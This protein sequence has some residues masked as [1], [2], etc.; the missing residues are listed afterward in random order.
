[1]L[2]KKHVLIICSLFLFYACKEESKTTFSETSITTKTNKLVE[3][4]IPKVM[5][6]NAIS[7]SINSEIKNLVMRALQ[8]GE[9]TSTTSKSIEESIDAFNE[10]YNAFNKDFPDASMPW[11][12][13]I[14]GEMLFESTEIISI[15]ITSYL[16][17]GGAHG[18][19]FIT[20]LNFNAQTGKRL[21][22]TDLIKNTDGFKTLAASYFKKALSDDDMLF[23]PDNFQ[24]PENMGYVEEGIHLLYNTYEIAPYATGIIE[25]T[26]PFEKARPFLVF[27][28]S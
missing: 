24:L 9:P 2:Y 10:E 27:K 14:D 23:K 1:M 12:A 25:F 7:N 21:K 19:T 4:N 6:D 13:Q 11:E 22:N 3:V 5:G 20:F 16:N 15:S 18:N 17:T 8:V 26:I 28:G